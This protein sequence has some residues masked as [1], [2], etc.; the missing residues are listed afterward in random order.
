M[1]SLRNTNVGDSWVKSFVEAQ[2]QIALTNVLTKINRRQAQ[3]PT[4]TSVSRSSDKELDKEYDIIKCLKA[5]MNNRYGADD[6]LQHQSIIVALATSLVSPRLSSRKLSSEVLAFLCHWANGEGHTKVLQAMDNVKHQ[7]GESGR[8]DAWMRIVEVSID[9]RGKM[10]SLVGASEEMRS[11]GIGMENLLMEYAVTTMFLINMLVDAAE[12]DLQLRVH[13]RAQFTSCGIK[14]V[15]LKM[16]D[17]QYDVIDKQIDRYRDNEAIDYE[18]ILSQQGGRSRDSVY[19]VKDM[20]DPV[21]IAEAIQSRVAG[22]KTSD[23]FL[24]SMQ[25]MLL[26][27]E[28]DSEDMQRMF[29]LV[30]SMLSYVAMDRR[31][32]DLELK[33]SLNFTMQS[34]LDRMYTSSEA[35]QAIEE[36]TI[37]KRTAD[38]AI[39]ERDDMREKVELGANGLVAKLQK[40]IEEQ[41]RHIEMQGRQNDSMKSEVTELQRLR[42]KEMQ[43]KELETRELY[44]MLRDAQDA[45]ESTGRRPGDAGNTNMDHKQVKGILDRERLMERLEIQL[46]RSKTQYKLEGKIWDQDGPSERLRELREKMDGTFEEDDEQAKA[47][48]QSTAEPIRRKPV[49]DARRMPIGSFIGHQA[50]ISESLGEIFKSK[51]LAESIALEKSRPLD[52]SRKIISED[53][54]IEDDGVTTG[55]SHPSLE[56]EQPKTPSDEIAAPPPPAPPLPPSLGGPPIPP[57]APPLP[58]FAIFPPPPSA[59]P[60]P[61]KLG[62][63]PPPPPPPPPPGAPPL[64]FSQSGK[65]LPVSELSP[66][67]SLPQL[68]FL[69]PKKK[70]KA[71]HWDK[72]DTPQ[73][74]LWANRA[75][76]LEDKEAKYIELSRKGV[77][78]EVERLFTAK[79]IKF[80]GATGGGKKSDKKQIIS[81]NLAHTFQI[82]MAK[83]S[84][85]PADKVIKMIIECD[86]QINNDHTVME[87][88]QKDDICIVSDNIA[89]LMA[90]YSIDWTGPDAKK[91]EREQDP[92]ELTRE[93]QIYL[94]TA[95]ELHH[96]WKSRMRALS[97]TRTF[98]SE[99]DEISKSLREV[100]QVCDSLRNSTSLFNVMC[101]ILDIG[102]F[103]ND[104]NKQATGFKLSSLSRLPMLKDDKNELT[105]QDAIESVVRRQYPEWETFLEEISGVILMKKVNIDQLL[106]DA[107]RYIENIKNVQSS[108]DGG[109]LSDPKRLH[110]QDRVV[111]VVARTMKDARRKAEQMQLYLEEAKKTY[112]EIMLFFGEDPLDE[113]ARRNFFEKFSSFIAQWRK[114]SSKNQEFEEGRRR[115]EASM[116]R[117]RAANPT[118][119]T[120][121]TS[122][123]GPQSPTNGAMDSLLE[124]LR[125][126]G[127]QPRENRDRRRRAR[128]K[129]KHDQRI[130][131]GEKMRDIADLSRNINGAAVAAAAGSGNDGADS[132][133]AASGLRSPDFIPA[134]SVLRREAGVSGSGDEHSEGEDVADRAMLLLHGLRQQ[135]IMLD[136]G[137]DS[138][139]HVRRRR[140][141][142][143]E[144]RVARRE[145]R[146]KEKQASAAANAAAANN[147]SDSASRPGFGP[148]ADKGGESSS[149]GLG[150]DGA[151]DYNEDDDEGDDEDDGDDDGDDDIVGNNMEPVI[152]SRIKVSV[153]PPAPLPH[154]S[155]HSNANGTKDKPVEILD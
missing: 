84:S 33:Q 76:T 24:S 111:Q 82:S 78:D 83:F 97:L 155:P 73:V 52:I 117:K 124:K 74:T 85:I 90:P 96:Y 10:G 41:S 109:N 92:E 126:A 15:L 153:I 139:L 143:E 13:V 12:G 133:S 91:T 19:T 68:P 113:N 26:L 147:T 64:P 31:L 146:R 137:S 140:E 27:R 44:L 127:P 39:A 59:P 17:F 66:S 103:M 152:R 79:E 53:D 49:N 87:F 2:G 54:D 36:A 93:D 104:A 110:P 80:L 128:L 121:P 4:H 116:A 100:E 30:N 138:A 94:K 18:D 81:S 134:P 75:G 45:A 11:G 61:G 122:P 16:A 145:A 151:A 98:E 37:A 35:E 58:G 123:D 125:A 131:S 144:R 115:N 34:V 3:G 56:S 23:Y 65:F 118:S 129:E 130:A 102:N 107:K 67:S 89:K 72:V 43:I 135:S 114:S 106:Q 22:S 142:G 119:S 120:T 48:Q 62:E 6:A 132:D 20:Q 21:Q 46:E 55:P 42:A 136:D 32:P 149:R 1:T 86:R 51:G 47:R 95:F 14:R 112:D 25:N 88:L 8:F 105:L 60:L 154:P 101:L 38:A 57:P 70:L 71:L 69:R 29:Q 148:G 40:T 9:G 108:L 77:L 5:L 141:N 50:E 150:L 63:I 7:Q 99:Y 28:N